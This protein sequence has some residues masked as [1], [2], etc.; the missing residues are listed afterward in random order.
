MGALLDRQW[1]LCNKSGVKAAIKSRGR[2]TIPA[3]IR[4]RLGLKAGDVLEF[5]E[6]APFVKACKAFN[7][8]AMRA[9]IGRGKHR[10]AGRTSEGWMEYLRGRL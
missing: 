10:G 9:A 2:I 5:D 3:E 1:R 8:E 6:K 7:R 4:R